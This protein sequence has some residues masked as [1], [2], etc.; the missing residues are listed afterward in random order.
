LKKN[1]QI[2][3]TRLRAYSDKN[4]RALALYTLNAFHLE[5]IFLDTLMDQV[6]DQISGFKQRDRALIHSL[7]YGV[8]RW[9]SYLDYIVVQLSHR[10]RSKTIIPVLNILRMG[11]FQMLFM[12]RI[13]EHAAVNTSVDLA[14]LFASKYETRFVNAIL[15]E[16]I[17]SKDRIQF[18][19][20]STQQFEYL[21]ITYAYPKWLIQ[22][23]ISYW[24]VSITKNLCDAGNQVPPIVLRTNT[25]LMNRSEL[26]EN[27]LSNAQTISKTTHAPDGVCVSN[28]KISIGKSEPFNK[29]MFQVQDEAA[30]LIGLI[31]SSEPGETV[32][33]A[34]AGRGGKTGHLAQSMNNKG[35]ILAVDQDKDKINILA[36]EMKRLGVSIVS[37]RQHHWKKTLGNHLFDRVLLDAP[38]SGLGV[39]RRHPD[40]KWKKTKANIFQNAKKQQRLIQIIASHVKPGGK[41]IYCVCSLE[42]EETSQIVEK[43]LSQ[44]TNFTIEKISNSILE[45]FVNKKGYYMFRPDIHLMDG[46][47]AVSFIR[48]KNDHPV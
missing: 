35:S 25:L 3:Q 4:P 2:I 11:L 18:P 45:T 29:G 24:G 33:D 5:D 34:C 21:S 37:T 9:R 1:N 10:S 38:C 43:F 44:H 30:Q 22:R 7:V 40:M 17:R 42:P 13:P 16:T 26:I 8:I 14:H 12:D 19:D 41:L 20:E 48:S 47:F 6:S 36:D 15:R 28:L 46:F 23:W 31:V 27:L 32:L 39:I